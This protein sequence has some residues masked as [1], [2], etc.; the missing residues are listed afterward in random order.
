MSGG[1]ATHDFAA[2]V[3][4]TGKVMPHT[5]GTIGLISEQELQVMKDTIHTENKRMENLALL[6]AEQWYPIIRNIENLVNEAG[7]TSY[8][9]V[10]AEIEQI[11]DEF[12]LN[13]CTDIYDAAHFKFEEIY[14]I[15]ALAIKT[16]FDNI[17]KTY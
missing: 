17:Y 2:R 4:S 5:E 10:E 11:R 15:N 8:N 13:D 7:W 12:N 16:Y 1:F 3:S 14:N 9:D 6:I